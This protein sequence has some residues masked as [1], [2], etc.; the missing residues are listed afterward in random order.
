MA[1]PGRHPPPP[2]PVAGDGVRVRWAGRR[3]K[4]VAAAV[5]HELEMRR[6]AAATTTAYPLQ[7]CSIRRSADV[8]RVLPMAQDVRCRPLKPTRSPRDRREVPSPARDPLGRPAAALL[9]RDRWSNYRICMRVR[10]VVTLEPAVAHFDGAPVVRLRLFRQRT[11]LYCGAIPNPF[12]PDLAAH[13][14]LSTTPAAQRAG[15]AGAHPPCAIRSSKPRDVDLG[16]AR[17]HVADAVRMVSASP[18]ASRR[19]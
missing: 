2:R 9:R 3:P 11:R 4:T 10:R 12:N 13:P 1:H 8:R 18:C 15:S 19:S 6:N 5:I 17:G 7:F 16:E 14:R